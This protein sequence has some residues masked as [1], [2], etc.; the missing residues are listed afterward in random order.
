MIILP[1]ADSACTNITQEGT[2]QSRLVPSN[3]PAPGIHLNAYPF[4]RCGSIYRDSYT[5]AEY[6]EQT[7]KVMVCPPYSMANRQRQPGLAPS[8]IHF[9]CD[10]H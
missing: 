9:Q 1:E 8:A 5:L 2:T 3:A 7:T 4:R 6:T 10:S